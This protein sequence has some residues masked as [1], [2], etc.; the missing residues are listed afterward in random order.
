M[1]PRFGATNTISVHANSEITSDD[2]GREVIADIVR[3]T[4]KKNDKYISALSKNKLS[5]T[6]SDSLSW[7]RGDRRTTTRVNKNIIKN[8]M[9]NDEN[10]PIHFPIRNLV[11][12]TELERERE[13]L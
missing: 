10:P 13:S 5:F 7:T 6:K 3:P 11:L 4:E 9:I 8:G 12:F 2:E 1:L